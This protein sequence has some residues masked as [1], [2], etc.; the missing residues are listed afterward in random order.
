MGP[1][2]GAEL[3]PG[4]AT[5]GGRKRFQQAQQLIHFAE[6]QGQARRR[7][8]QLAG[9]LDQIHQHQP[10]LVGRNH[11]ALAQLAQSL[12]QGRLA[13]PAPGRALGSERRRRGNLQLHAH[14]RHQMAAGAG[15]H[16]HLGLGGRAWIHRHRH[17]QGLAQGAEDEIMQLAIVAEAHLVLVRVGIHIE[18]L[19]LHVQIEHI[20]RQAKMAH[21][22]LVGIV[23][24]VLNEFVAN[25]AAVEENVLLVGGAVVEGRQA[26]PAAQAD[27]VHL[28]FHRNGVLEKLL[29]ENLGHARAHVAAKIPGNAAVVAQQELHVGIAEGEAL[30]QLHHVVGFGA[31]GFEE[32]L[33][34]RGVVEQVAHLNGGA[35]R[36]GRRYQLAR[37]GRIDAVAVFLL[38]GATDQQH[39]GHRRHRGKRFAAKAQGAQPLQIVELANLAGGVVLEGPGHIVPVDAAAVVADANQLAAAVFNVDVNL[40]GAG[41]QGVF[42]HLLHHRRGPFDNLAG[43]NLVNQLLR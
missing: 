11:E 13:A 21:E 40:G 30:H 24:G 25:D 8:V 42:H 34:G 32:A 9:G 14:I 28:V 7:P 5:P 26:N 22:I 39:L 29:A 33:P 2:L 43:L 36:V 31:H 4:G 27:A 18:Q 38:L 19:R 35:A 23:D 6:G 17:V 10:V 15:G 41:V 3:H 16:G 12:A 37:V 1:S 20:D